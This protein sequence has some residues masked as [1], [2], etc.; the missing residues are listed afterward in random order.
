MG[1]GGQSGGGGTGVDSQSMS[2][3]SGGRPHSNSVG[4]DVD[5]RH[6]GM[7]LLGETEKQNHSRWT[8][9]IIYRGGWGYLGQ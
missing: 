1:M 2:P 6:G 9:F 4:S 3:S 7:M 8:S 5:T